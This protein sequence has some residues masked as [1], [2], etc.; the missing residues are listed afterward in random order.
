MMRAAVLC[1]ATALAAAA[2]VVTY[3]TLLEPQP[4]RGGMTPALAAASNYTLRVLDRATYPRAVCLDGSMA[5]YYYRAG[6]SPAD[7]ARFRIFFQGGGWCTS[8]A[9]CAARAKTPLGSNAGLPASDR[10]PAGYCGAS[11]LSQDPAMA[12][13][14]ATWPGIYVPYCTGDS[15][16]GRA[17]APVSVNGSA[18]WY[19]GA[20]SRDAILADMRSL[21]GVS[22]ATDVLVGGCSAG[23]LTV[24]LNI[25]A[26]AA[27]LA[28]AKVQGVADAG[29]FLDH[30]D[31]NGVPVRT[32]FFQWGFTA[33]NSSASL[34]PACLAAYPAGEQWRCIFAQYA[35]PYIATPVFALNSRF[36][37]C[38][39][40]G[41]EL[42]LPTVS[43]GW[44]NM[45]PSDQAAAES[46]AAAF[47]A[48]FAPFAAKPLNGGFIVSCLLH[49]QAGTANYNSTLVAN[50]AGGTKISPGAAVHAWYSGATPAGGS[51][52][53]DAAPLPPSNP[54]C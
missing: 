32:P 12:P 10:D 26:M 11:F 37:S 13:G 28:P 54:T 8:D 6:T 35:A 52:W 39:L 4:A 30:P 27:A 20:D 9:D 15:L 23:G 46:Y 1:A 50:T 5:A 18:I 21:L 48:A 34:S 24:Y 22:A 42:D 16:T 33:W 44:P 40:N 3:A 17:D 2:D 43:K 14:F 25:D 51:L 45:A 19:R 31:H 53:I 36:D 7:G 47:M 41:C 29:F 49:C 38:Q